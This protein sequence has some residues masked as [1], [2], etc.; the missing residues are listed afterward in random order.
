[1]DRSEEDAGVLGELQEVGA[2]SVLAEEGAEVVEVFQEAVAAALHH[3][4]EVVRGVDSHED[5]DDYLDVGAS[6]ICCFVDISAFHGLCIRCW[7]CQ[8]V[9]IRNPVKTGP[10]PGLSK[11]DQ[12]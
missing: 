7:Y 10:E 2:V 8:G 9:L 6:A 5:V 11:V 3:E 1:M 4:E 12:C